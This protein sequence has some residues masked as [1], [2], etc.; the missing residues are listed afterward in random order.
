MAKACARD[1]KQK[2]VDLSHV[3][4]SE[5][6]WRQG[7][8][9]RGAEDARLRAV[10]V[11]AA[12]AAVSAAATEAKHSS[13]SRATS[14]R[15]FRRQMIRPHYMLSTTMRHVATDGVAWSVCVL[16][17]TVNPAKTAELIEM[18]FRDRLA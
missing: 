15:R 12:A 17:T 16:V 10:A 9:E 13:Q 7:V 8:A 2:S 14:A 11:A 3:I 1:D 18:S 5:V 6:T 4:A